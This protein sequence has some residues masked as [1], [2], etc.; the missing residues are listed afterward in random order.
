MEA[1]ITPSGSPGLLRRSAVL[2]VALFAAV[3]LLPQGAPATDQEPEKME[4]ARAALQKW[5]ETRKL[6]SQEQK[7]WRLEEQLIQNRIRVYEGEISDLRTRIAEM[8]VSIT[9]SQ[10]TEQELT[11]ESTALKASAASLRDRVTA[12]EAQVKELLKRMPDQVKNLVLPLSRSM[13]ENP[14]ET[15]LS[16]SVRYRNIVNILNLI[17]KFNREI[18]LKSEVRTLA[19]GQ[20]AD[21][22]V[23]YFGVGQAYYATAD[24]SAAGIGTVGPEGWIWIP[25][26]EHAEVIAEAIAIYNND[27][28]AAFVQLPV[29]IQ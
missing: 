12:L 3:A 27:A 23:L 15:E 14:E 22:Q 16:L 2:A 24:L 13:P 28:P 9:E 20:Q 8:K 4:D 26:N 5:V 17:N 7:E 1:R 25:A 18:H 10:G 29:Q 11:A 21:V 6:I 19:N